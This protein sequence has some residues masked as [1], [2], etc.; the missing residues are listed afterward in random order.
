MASSPQS[1]GRVIIVLGMH[2][3]GTSVLTECIHLLG[4]DIASQVIPPEAA[5]NRDGFFEDAKIVALNEQLL[6]LLGSS[7]YDFRSLPNEV[8]DTSAMQRWRTEA[9]D[10]LGRDYAGASLAVIKDPRMSR[11]F[12]FWVPVFQQANL[13]VE[14]VHILR[15]PEEV[16][17]SLQRRNGMPPAYGLL[18]WCAHIID[19]LK[20]LETNAATTT[21]LYDAFVDDPHKNIRL[22]AN[23]LAA[24]AGNESDYAS[25]AAV[26]GKPVSVPS[27]SHRAA[28][29]LI[30][31]LHEFALRLYQSLAGRCVDGK[32]VFASGERAQLASDYE[33]L[34]ARYPA[35]FATLRVLAE[36]LII[37]NGE[38][39]RIGELHA[40]AQAIVQQRDDQLAAVNR[41]LTRVGA[42]LE[43]AQSIV[44]ER[45]EQLAALN[46]QKNTQVADLITRVARFQNLWLRRG[47]RQPPDGSDER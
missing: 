21:V 9:L 20:S 40:N 3:S 2:R 47:S 8:A 33:S 19:S 11:L 26:V 35:A 46:A 43:Y 17:I 12:A 5:I 39:V 24:A 1:T 38:L 22:M 45:D 44:A 10:H 4:A 18:L 14:L 36:E 29:A 7:W 13:N 6:A 37:V 25:I 32:L 41:E 42:E 23:T 30:P 34:I 15:Q 27:P 31:E 16:A 28:L